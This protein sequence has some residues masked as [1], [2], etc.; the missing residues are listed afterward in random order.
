MRPLGTFILKVVNR[1]NIDCDYC[2][3]FNGP[4]QS[5]RA[6]PARM[7]LDTVQAAASRINEHVT[8]HR[9]DRVDAVLHGGEPLLAGRQHLGA[10]LGALRATIGVRLDIQIQ[11]NG[12]LVDQQWLDVFEEFHVRVGVSL[13]GPP[14]ANSRHRLTQR[15]SPTVETAVRGIQLLRSRPGLFAG[16]LAVVDIRNDP[17]DTYRY[18][19][20]LGPPVIDFNL[21]HATHDR[22]PLRLLAGTPEYGQWLSSIY[23]AW[24][25]APAFTHTIRMFEDI[26]ALTLGARGS[27]ESLGLTPS[28]IIV[29]ESDGSIEDVD[30]LK[31]VRSGAT[32]LDLNV[33]EHSFDEAAKHPAIRRRL[34]GAALLAEQCQQCSLV[35]VCGGGYL[36]HRFSTAQGYRNPSVYCHDL[37]HLIKHIGTTLPPAER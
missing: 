11:S 25:S 6:L 13:D 8:A 2:Y 23:D 27:V 37:M 19:A 26:V 21:P 7:D 22:P 34:L 29:V 31:S 16:I 32:R 5:W 36:P 9:L 28:N 30:T 24:T 15:G 12:V 4:D 20:A 18:L 17:V 35:S 33:F 1:C 14:E 10:L 3:V